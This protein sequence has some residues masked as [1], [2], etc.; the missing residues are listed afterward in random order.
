MYWIYSI[1][2]SIYPFHSSTH[3]S[4]CWT[5]LK[6]EITVNY[7]W[8]MHI[9]RHYYN[10]NIHRESLNAFV[11]KNKGNQKAQIST[12]RTKENSE[13]KPG[14]W[15]GDKF[16]LWIIHGIN[17]LPNHRSVP[18]TLSINFPACTAAGPASP[19]EKPRYSCE[20]VQKTSCSSHR[21]VLPNV[22]M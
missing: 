2:Y 15:A 20:P 13:T 17:Y 12:R 11:W 8:I 21:N 6:G 16:R 9:S 1:Y 7:S 22:C 14:S 18:Q 3:P 5:V 10:N 19:E 4:K